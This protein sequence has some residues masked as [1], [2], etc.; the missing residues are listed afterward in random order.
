MA[1]LLAEKRWDC[2]R[3]VYVTVMAFFDAFALTLGVNL[4]I[5]PIFNLVLR[6]TSAFTFPFRL[7]VPKPSSKN[8]QGERDATCACVIQR[9][10]EGYHH[11]GFE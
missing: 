1:L 11:I 8:D 4:T 7:S 6:Y 3:S 2:T 5:G 9:P 10:P